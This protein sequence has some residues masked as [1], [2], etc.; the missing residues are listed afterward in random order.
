MDVSSAEKHKFAI[1]QNFNR[2]A[3]TYDQAAIVQQE[4][5]RRLLERLD[6]LTINPHFILDLGSGTGFL[7]KALTKKYTSSHII[8]LDIAK[9][10]LSFS[11]QTSAQETAFYLCADGEHLP[12]KSQSIDLLVSNCVFHWFANPQQALK[13]MLRVLKPE[14]LLFFSTFGPDTLMELRQS[15]FS[16]DAEVKEQS[17]DFDG[18]VDMHEIGD[19]LL[20]N[21]FSDPV[22]DKEIITITYKN[23]FGLLKDLQQ[24]GGYLP[25]AQKKNFSLVSQKKYLRTLGFAYK[26]HQSKTEELP[27]TFEVIYG[28]ALAHNQKNLRRQNEAGIIQIPVDDL[29]YL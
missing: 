1:R 16:I 10:M 17:S 19:W 28:H 5:G 25:S 12:I 6:L 29:H 11:K 24:T 21:A 4:I 8:N 23:I 9:E 15:L 7:A 3:N 13:E 2:V 20:Q 27:A 14:G 22:I 26:Q 18:L